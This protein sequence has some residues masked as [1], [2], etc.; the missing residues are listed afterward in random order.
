M[1]EL[2]SIH[3]ILS[4]SH[5]RLTLWWISDIIG[6]FVDLQGKVRSQQYVYSSRTSYLHCGGT[7]IL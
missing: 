6:I 3:G 5:A 2:N 4:F 1:K 7:L